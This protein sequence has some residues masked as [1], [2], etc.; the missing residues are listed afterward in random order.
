MTALAAVIDTTQVDAVPEQAPLHPVKPDPLAALAVKVTEAPEE[1]LALHV[2][3]Q[4]MP[5]G[6]LTTVPLPAPDF[7]TLSA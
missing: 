1:K 5:A 2:E 6:L 4:L 3:P 7:V